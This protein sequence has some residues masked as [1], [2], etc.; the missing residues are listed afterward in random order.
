MKATS[1]LAYLHLQLGTNACPFDLDYDKWSIFAP[2]SWTKMLWR[3]MDVSGF[4][5]HLAYDEIDM[6]RMRD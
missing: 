4:S 2:L 5:F 3:T 6:P 1:S